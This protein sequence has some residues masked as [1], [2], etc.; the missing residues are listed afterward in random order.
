MADDAAPFGYEQYEWDDMDEAEKAEIRAARAKQ[1][2]EAE[3]AREAIR[4][5]NLRAADEMDENEGKFVQTEV[6]RGGCTG[7]TVA[8]FLVLFAL[9]AAGALAVKNK[10]DDGKCGSAPPRRDGTA[11]IACNKPADTAASSTSDASSS[12]GDTASSSSGGTAGGG[13][14][15][16]PPPASVRPGQI[17]FQ[18]QTGDNIGPIAQDGMNRFVSLTGPGVTTDGNSVTI[19]WDKG[20]GKV[21]SFGSNLHTSTNKGRYGFALFRNVPATP[22]TTSP[23]GE[24]DSQYRA[25]CAIEVG[26][27]SCKS[28][29]A[30]A[31]IVNGDRVTIIIG[32]AGTGVG[33]YS[34]DWWFVYQPD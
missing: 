4:A 17:L 8:I 5:M 6:K 19:T 1:E 32:E 30:G 18:G 3:K 14:A 27:T 23:S 26:Q 15:A 28:D 7:R 20:A 11:L 22:P 13:T 29:T 33:D 12:S 10:S 9:G 34:A 2:A 16:I 31:P 21:V 25:G 24:A